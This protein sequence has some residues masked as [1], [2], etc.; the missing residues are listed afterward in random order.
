MCLIKF[1]DSNGKKVRASRNCPTCAHNADSDEHA[2][3][4]ILIRIFV[5][6]MNP[7]NLRWTQMSGDMFPNVAPH[8]MFKILWVGLV[9]LVQQQ[10]TH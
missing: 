2:H 7:L 3:P 1:Q 6:R 9:Q 5:F 4:R 10:F 8:K